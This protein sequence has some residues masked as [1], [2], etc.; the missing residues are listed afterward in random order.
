M[1]PNIFINKNIL[2]QNKH[3]HPLLCLEGISF[4]DLNNI[5]N[6]IYN[7][8]I[9]IYQKDLDSFVT[10]AERL[11]LEGLIGSGDNLNELLEEEQKFK[12]DDVLTQEITDKM[13]VAHNNFSEVSE[14]KVR[15]ANEKKITVNSEEFQSIEELDATIIKNMEKSGNGKWICNVCNRQFAKKDHTKEH[16]E[17]HF[18]GLKFPCQYCDYFTKTRHC[19]RDHISKHHKQIKQSTAIKEAISLDPQLYV[20][21]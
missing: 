4:K 10:I 3:Q 11:K 13:L 7:G 19:L 8:E 2:K 6:Y 1:F 16:M 12:I 18:D 5:L 20:N 21:F 9:K 15:I 17:T 14:K